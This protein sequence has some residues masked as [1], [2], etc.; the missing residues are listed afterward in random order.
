MRSLPAEFETSGRVDR[1]RTSN[2]YI[3]D[4]GLD[5]YTKLGARLSAVTREQVKATAEKYIQPDKVIVV[6]VGDR[7]QIARRA[8]EAESRGIRGEERRRHTGR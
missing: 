6:A 4:L 1:A 8:A 5:Y 3:Y 7:A 2:I